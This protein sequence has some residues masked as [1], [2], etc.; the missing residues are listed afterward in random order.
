M[1]FHQKTDNTA[2]VMARGG[3]NETFGLSENILQGAQMFKSFLTS[4]KLVV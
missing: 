3:A 1:V 2:G 4:R